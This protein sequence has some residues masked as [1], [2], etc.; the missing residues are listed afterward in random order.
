MGGPAQARGAKGPVCDF[1]VNAWGCSGTLA[2]SEGVHRCGDETGSRRQ[3]PLELPGISAIRSALGLGQHR[4]VA[5][6]VRAGPGGVDGAAR[7]TVRPGQG[8]G[9]ER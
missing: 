2:Y 9:G 1:P 8:A 7:E 5:V 6:Q 3:I 4:N